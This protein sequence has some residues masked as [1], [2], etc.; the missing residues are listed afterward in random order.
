MKRV[1]TVGALAAALVAGTAT[2][3][4]AISI[5]GTSVTTTHTVTTKKPGWTCKVITS[6]LKYADGS[7]RNSTSNGCLKT[8]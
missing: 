3:T 6:T 8:K 7:W 1:I 2:T 4:Y 5:H